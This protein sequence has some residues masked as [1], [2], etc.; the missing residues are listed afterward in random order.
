[1]SEHE[2]PV[3]LTLREIRALA[4]AANFTISILGTETDTR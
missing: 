2:I 3:A 4:A 1:M